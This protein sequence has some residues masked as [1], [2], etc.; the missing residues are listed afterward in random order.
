MGM[1]LHRGKRNVFRKR[2]PIYRILGWSLAAVVIVALGFFGAKWLTEHPVV[3]PTPDEQPTVE[4]TTTTAPTTQ[5]TQPDPEPEAPAVLTDLRGFYLP[6]S[7]LTA[8]TLGDT[9]SAAKKAG[10]NGVIFDLKDTEGN[11]YYRFTAAA[12][13]QVN[14]YV[15]DALTEEQLSDLFTAI[16]KAGLTPIPRLHAFRDNAAARALAAARITHA[17][18]SGWVWYDGNPKNGGKA[19]LNPYA[20]EAHSY[21]G[22]LAAELRDAGAG[23]I[24]LD[25]VQFPHQLSSASFGSSSNVNMKEEEVLALFV[26]RIRETL[27]EECPVILSCT[28]E[29]ALGTAT[30]VYGGNPLTFGADMAAPA[31]LPADLPAKIKVGDATVENT[32]DTLQNTVKELVAHMILRTK[33]LENAP[34]VTPFLQVDGY[35]AAQVKAEIDG[36]QEGGSSSYILYNP[37]GKYDFAAY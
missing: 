9:L 19:W 22:V 35:K 27:G 36:C 24:I 7:A 12:A 25:S 32:P 23:A 17:D 29:S 5:P 13:Q 14:S 11:L 16:R 2:N 3:A 37:K 4:S 8:D 21:I 20:D 28:A 6:H 30:Q 10:F 34:A 18:N 26:K 15:E 1:K 31:I 33:V